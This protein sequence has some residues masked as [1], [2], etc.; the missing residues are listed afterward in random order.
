M[1][2][3]WDY[4]ILE[5]DLIEGTELRSD[6]IL[7]RRPHFQLQGDA[8]FE[9]GS[10]NPRRKLSAAET[11]F[12]DLMRRRVSVKE[13]REARGECADAMIR[14][15]VGSEFCEVVEPV[16]PG[17]R[18]RVLVIEPH[19]DDAA[20]SLGGTMW[21]R[22]LECTFVVAT[23]ASRSNHV[24]YRDLGC[25]YFDINEVTELRRRES[26]LFAGMVGGVHVSVGMSDA[27]LRYRD[28]HWTAEFFRR[29][30]MSI[31][32]ATSRIADDRERRRWTDAVRRLLTEQ[33]SAEVWF[34][35]G[36]P[37]ADHMLTADACFAAFLEDPSLVRGRILRVYQEF[38]YAA[39]FPRHMTDALN[40]LK[41][42]GAVLEE[43][44]VPIDNAGE[45]KLRL[46]SV[47]D[48]QEIEE[49][50]ADTQASALGHGLT[51]G[52]AE[53]LWTLK[54]L[55]ERID[56]AGI[57]SGAM[58]GHNQAVAVQMWLSRNKQKE[59]LRVLLPMPTGRWAADLEALCAAFPH[60][61]FE[62][63]VAPAA[64]AEVVDAPSDRV[65]VR[66]VAS[67]AL[68]WIL[69]SC[70]LSLEM[71]A[72]P[73]LF[74]AGARR[75]RQARLLAKLWP[76]SDTLIVASMDALVSALQVEL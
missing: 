16:F 24:R 76:R 49:M 32:V 1:A 11:R 2:A 5:N 29:H 4:D 47:Y 44:P 40:A 19:A 31:Q 66:K 33:P 26:E 27:V 46:A 12:W 22:R 25:D 71:R 68:S 37:H 35:L 34:P 50:R 41:N 15:F 8:L 43:N 3:N 59:R 56:P 17:D 48:S 36:G 54:S 45:Q 53:L 67:G 23:M 13:V 73:T 72:P 64:E 14:E 65:E 63:Y 21:L 55:P 28:A 52:P 20:L 75:E 18:R 38:P 42:A 51:A 39:R 62:V 60:A 10:K 70:R 7:V 61:K 58:A 6:Y 57:V 69:L 74:H 30:Q 9:P